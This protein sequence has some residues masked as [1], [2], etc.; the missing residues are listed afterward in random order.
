MVTSVGKIRSD[1][2]DMSSYNSVKITIALNPRFPKQGL[3]F[4]VLIGL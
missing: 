1:N 2:V 3:S 4:L